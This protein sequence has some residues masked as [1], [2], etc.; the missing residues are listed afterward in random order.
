MSLDELCSKL[1]QYGFDCDPQEIK[2]LC[3]TDEELAGAQRNLQK[4]LKDIE[5][6]SA[7]NN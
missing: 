7:T 4:M 1:S 2:R 5:K 6:E 3:S